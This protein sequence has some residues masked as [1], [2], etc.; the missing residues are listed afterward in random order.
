MNDGSTIM[1]GAIAIIYR[2]TPRGR[3]Y[4]VTHN[5]F[6]GN[7]TF[8]GGASD[9]GEEMRDTIKRELQEEINFIPAD[10]QI[11][12]LPLTNSFVFSIQGSSRYKQ[13]AKYQVFLVKTEVEEI[14][15]NTQ[16]VSHAYWLPYEQAREMVKHEI[17]KINLDW[18]ERK[19]NK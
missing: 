6:S 2:E 7:H 5:V 11:E 14:T 17:L 9:S 18:V 15:P 3:V 1:N 8:P 4:L 16:Q 12:E 13:P 10:E 19:L